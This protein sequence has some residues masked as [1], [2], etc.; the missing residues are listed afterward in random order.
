[1]SIL[2]YV[3]MKILLTCALS[4]H[5]L[6][7]ML[8]SMHYLYI[9]VIFFVQVLTNS[10]SVLLVIWLPRLSKCVYSSAVSISVPIWQVF[11]VI[12]MMWINL[13]NL[14]SWVYVG[15]K[16]WFCMFRPKSLALQ[17]GLDDLSPNCLIANVHW[18]I[19]F[20]DDGW[21]VSGQWIICTVSVHL[22]CILRNFWSSLLIWI[23]SVPKDYMKT[24]S[25]L[26][27]MICFT[28][29]RSVDSCLCFIYFLKM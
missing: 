8:L 26:S 7:Y 20:L 14:E 12:F 29:L 18:M 9:I 23:S 28:F 17:C 15:L 27:F 24:Y 21:T 13:M 2:S 25:L 10:Y 11:T 3:F 19:N 22:Q 5:D 1:M 4:E 16:V 6:I